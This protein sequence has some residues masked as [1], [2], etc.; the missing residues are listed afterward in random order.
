MKIFKESTIQHKLDIA[1]GMHI[2]IVNNPNFVLENIPNSIHYNSFL[3]S[4]LAIAFV[5]DIF[6][7]I[8]ILK[9]SSNLIY[10]SGGLWIATSSGNTISKDWGPVRTRALSFSLKDYKGASINAFLEAKLFRFMGTRNPDSNIDLEQIFSQ[11]KPFSGRV[12]K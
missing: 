1:E 5:N 11:M 7:V 9:A 8:P 6:D 10:S 2:N 12:V 3:R 4:D